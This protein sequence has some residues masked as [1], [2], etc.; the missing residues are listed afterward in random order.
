MDAIK[1]YNEFIPQPSGLTIICYE[2]I[3]ISVV[4]DGSMTKLGATLTR[5]N[6]D[7]SYLKG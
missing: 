3:K 1:R 7:V 5:D 4:I 2:N 6:N